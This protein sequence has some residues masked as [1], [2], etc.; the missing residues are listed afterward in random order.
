MLDRL[1]AIVND[2]IPDNW[3]IVIQ[4]R[5]G[6]DVVQF[7]LLHSGTYHGLHD[8]GPMI[9]VEVAASYPLRMLADVTAISKELL[10]LVN[11]ARF[12]MNLPQLK[13][14]D[15]L[16]PEQLEEDGQTNP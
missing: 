13:T 2:T 7:R 10:R 1:I 5:Q 11:H 15:W 16:Q 9:F 8:V 12:D 3:W 4:H 14:G 6:D